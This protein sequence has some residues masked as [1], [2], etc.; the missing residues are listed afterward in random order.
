VLPTLLEVAGAAPADRVQGRSLLPLIGGETAGWKNT[1]FSELPWSGRRRAITTDAH[2]ILTSLDGGEVEVYDYIRDRHEQRPL[3]ESAW[4]PA[5]RADLERLREWSRR[6]LA[7]AAEEGAP[8]AA[9][10]PDPRAEEQLRAL[11]YVQ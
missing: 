3:P 6:Q 1:A 9:A 8:A 5:I 2:H 10:A 7:I 11:G 4:T